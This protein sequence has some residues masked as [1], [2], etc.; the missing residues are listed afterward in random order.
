MTRSKFTK[1]DGLITGFSTD[2][3]AG[4]GEQGYDV[5]CA[6]V[7]SA[8]YLTANTVTEIYRCK[9]EL[10]ERDGHL[11][12]RLT[13]DDAARC[14]PALQGLLLHLKELQKQYP[15]HLQVRIDGQ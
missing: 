14:Q 3:H 2:G 12:L 15:D 7:S 11:G 5:V 1:T 13:A 10:E 6:A 9:A 4:A 8:V